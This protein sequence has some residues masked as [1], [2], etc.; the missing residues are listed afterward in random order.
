MEEG[1]GFGDWVLGVGELLDRGRSNWNC[2]LLR[3]K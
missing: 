1:V 2:V 3:R